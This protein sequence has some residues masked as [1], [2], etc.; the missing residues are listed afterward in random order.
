MAFARIANEPPRIWG[1][2]AGQVFATEP[3]ASP[4]DKLSDKAKLNLKKGRF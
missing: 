3:S 2:S 1:K 4:V